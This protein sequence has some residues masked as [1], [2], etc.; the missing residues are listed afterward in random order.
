MRATFNQIKQHLPD[1]EIKS[2][3]TGTEVFDWVVPNEWKVNDAYI[4]TPDGE[5]ICKFADNNL[6]LLGYSIPFKGR[7]SLPELRKHLYTLPEQPD[8][9]PY[10]TSY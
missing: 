9:I 6:H 1:L 7:V 4:V 2:I 5:K 3:P 10:I 8:A